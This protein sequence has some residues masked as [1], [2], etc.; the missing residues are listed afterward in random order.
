MQFW[1]IACSLLVFLN[2]TI[3]EIDQRSG[4]ISEM[5]FQAGGKTSKQ[6]Q[7]E[8]WPKIIVLTR[9]KQFLKL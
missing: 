2:T 8:V 7:S 5:P 9:R 3:L 1:E 4:V 6:N